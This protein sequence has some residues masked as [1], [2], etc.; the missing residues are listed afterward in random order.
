MIETHKVRFNSFRPSHSFPQIKINIISFALFLI[1]SGVTLFLPSLAEA[2]GRKPNRIPQPRYRMNPPPQNQPLKEPVESETI[3]SQN[4]QPSQ[5]ESFKNM[6]KTES[7]PAPV[8]EEAPP[9]EQSQGANEEYES[10]FPPPGSKIY[11]VW[12]WQE[13]KDC[14]WNLAK[15]YYKDPWQWKKIYLANRNNILEPNVIF[16]KQKIVIPQGD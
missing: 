7:V 16:P 1:M 15:K 6:E 4:T 14:L 5:T 9:K 10:V 13:T 2:K 3:S 11:T 12:I 8:Q